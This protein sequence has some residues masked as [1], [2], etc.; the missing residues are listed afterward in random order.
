M[1]ENH[2]K[3]RTRRVKRYAAATGVNYH[4]FASGQRQVCRPEG[5]GSGTDFTF[6][7]TADRRAPAVLRVFVAERASHAWREATGRELD[8]GES[9]A[10]AK[11]RLFQALDELADPYSE[12]FG[13]VVDESNVQSLLEPLDIE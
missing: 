5:Q 10:A 6:V 13:L 2:A 1:E 3:A 9:Y 12:R 8:P 4:Y 11:L 7:V